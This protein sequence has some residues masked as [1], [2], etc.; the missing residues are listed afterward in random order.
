MAVLVMVF[1][2]CWALVATEVFE[3]DTRTP[4]VVTT[5]AFPEAAEKAWNILSNQQGSALDAVE[6]G[7]AV[8]EYKQCDFTV[9]FGGSPDEVGET[10]LDS[11]I[12]DG[13]S[14]NVG[15]VAGLKRIKNA[16][17]VARKVL[18]TTRHT[19]L[20][21]D[22]ATEFALEMGFKEEN[23]TTARS[24]EEHARW[25]KGNCQPNF[26]VNV[27]PDPSKSCGPYSP[28]PN[29]SPIN[30]VR[31]P[32]VHSEWDSHD[33]IGMLAVDMN[34]RIASATSTNGAKNKVPGR[35]GDSPIPGSG[36][37]ADGAIGAAAATGDGDVM[38][39]F[40]PSFFAVEE[41]RRGMHPEAAAE[42]AVS[43]VSAKYPDFKGAVVTLRKDGVYG[44]ACHGL[45]TFPYVVATAETGKVQLLHKKCSKAN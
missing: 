30:S 24:E 43:R 5:W 3:A 6:Q 19:L 22:S 41:M 31:T 42:A 21:G 11:M 8:C 15:A 2:L 45:D 7:C 23:L 35:V 29:P 36:S 27:L 20:V 1:A 28:I 37:Y 25:R 9:G 18:E 32:S 13:T 39:R 26:R 34:H 12:M 10:T 17:G 14:M 40:V 38:M 33:T 16:I 44:A 4:V